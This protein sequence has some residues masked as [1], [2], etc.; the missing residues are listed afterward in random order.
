MFLKLN[1]LFSVGLPCLLVKS[2]HEDSRGIFTSEPTPIHS[3]IVQPA[4]PPCPSSLSSLRVYSLGL[5]D[6]FRGI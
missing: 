6:S 1:S 5:L 2:D 3:I 4:K